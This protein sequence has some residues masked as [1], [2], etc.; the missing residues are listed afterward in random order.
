MEVSNQND[1][2]ARYGWVLVPENVTTSDS[3]DVPSTTCGGLKE[4]L[5]VNMTTNWVGSLVKA[6]RG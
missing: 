6:R 4:E 3:G 5:L 2:E 1:P